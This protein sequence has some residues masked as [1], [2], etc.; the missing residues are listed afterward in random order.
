MNSCPYLLQNYTILDNWCFSRKINSLRDIVPVLNNGWDPDTK[1]NGMT[2]PQVVYDSSDPWVRAGNLWRNFWPSETCELSFIYLLTQLVLC[3]LLLGHTHLVAAL[4]MQTQYTFLRGCPSRS[5][6]Y[7][8]DR[9][10]WELMNSSNLCK[11][12]QPVVHQWKNQWKQ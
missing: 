7:L 4:I 8:V 12:F 9:L 2:N 5:D 11:G 3:K 6:T 1:V 10:S